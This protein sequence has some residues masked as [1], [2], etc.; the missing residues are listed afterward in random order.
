MKLSE[1]SSPE[2]MFTPSDND[3]LLE[4][5]NNDTV[6]DQSPDAPLKSSSPK[7]SK[8]VKS[9]KNNTTR[10][11][12]LTK[13]G[14]A[15][16]V[17]LGEIED[18]KNIDE[19]KDKVNRALNNVFLKQSF[20]DE[21]AHIEVKVVNELKECKDKFKSW[22][23]NFL[24]ENNLTTATLEDIQ[25]DKLADI[26]YKKIKYTESS[27]KSWKKERDLNSRGGKV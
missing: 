22:E 11:K 16:S 9:T 5:E 3:S 12:S 20:M 10:W 19:K 6:S 7:S 26:L 14:N 1:T 25:S 2:A 13:L 18:V 24:L 21:R 27:I 4:P 8:H 17:V 23:K 15:L